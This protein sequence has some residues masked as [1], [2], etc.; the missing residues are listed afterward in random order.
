MDFITVVSIM[1]LVSIPVFAIYKMVNPRPRYKT[2][3][4]VQLIQRHTEEWEKEKDI[5]LLI[6]KVGKKNYLCN[7]CDKNGNE[8]YG[9]EDKTKPFGVVH[10]V[11]R[12]VASTGLRTG[13]TVVK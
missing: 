1:F 13:L 10:L 6:K 2:G 12:K 9:G 3:D 11:F 8:I 5:Y 7:W 4:I